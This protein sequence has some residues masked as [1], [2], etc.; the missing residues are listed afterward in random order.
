[1]NGVVRFPNGDR[2]RGEVLREGLTLSGKGV[3]NFE[4][5]ECFEGFFEDGLPHD[6]AGKMVLTDGVTEVERVVICLIRLAV[7]V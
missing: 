1:V 7:T 4:N 5:G 3:M 6:G 2:Y